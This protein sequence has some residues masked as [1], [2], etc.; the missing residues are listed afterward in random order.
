MP[1][2]DPIVHIPLLISHPDYQSTAGSRR[3]GLTQCLDVPATLLDIM[4]VSTPDD[5]EGRSV[6]PLVQHNQSI[7]EH[8]LFGIFKVRWSL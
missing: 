2:R 5:Y 8:A 6:M 4:G 7:R 3:G 1:M